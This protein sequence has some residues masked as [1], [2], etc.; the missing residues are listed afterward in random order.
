MPREP[1]SRGQK[2]VVFENL[3][4]LEKKR[5]G[6]HK[7]SYVS[8]FIND[9]TRGMPGDKEVFIT[10]YGHEPS[11]DAPYFIAYFEGVKETARSRKPWK[12][13]VIRGGL[14]LRYIEEPSRIDPKK[15]LEE[16][17]KKV[18]LEG[19]K[20]ARFHLFGFHPKTGERISH[21]IELSK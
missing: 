19:L 21:T 14:F 6:W 18:D 4:V 3:K 15:V 10:R 1:G 11:S 5:P 9:P 12:P 2:K 13:R 16:L 7:A 17:R 8:K 20:N